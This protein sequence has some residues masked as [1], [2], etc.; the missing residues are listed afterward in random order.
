MIGPARLLS[1]ATSVAVASILF[2]PAAVVAPGTPRMST[3]VT[4]GRAV[5]INDHGPRCR[6]GGKDA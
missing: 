6:S 5:D 2:A 4:D 1:G 3:I